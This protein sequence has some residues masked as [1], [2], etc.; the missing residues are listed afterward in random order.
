MKSTANSRMYNAGLPSGPGSPVCVMIHD[1]LVSADAV[2]LWNDIVGATVV[3]RSPK[4]NPECAGPH[5]APCFFAHQKCAQAELRARCFIGVA[6]R[7][8]LLLQPQ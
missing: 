4:P 5:T 2:K 6:A 7:I 1:V 8:D 3:C